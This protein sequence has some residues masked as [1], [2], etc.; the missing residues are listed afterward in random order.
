MSYTLL[1]KSVRFFYDFH[2]IDIPIACFSLTRWTSPKWPRPITFLSS[3]SPTF[4]RN[5]LSLVTTGWSINV[6]NQIRKQK[7]KSYEISYI[8]LSTK[9]TVWIS[10]LV[11]SVLHSSYST[12]SASMSPSFVS[13]RWSLSPSNRFRRPSKMCWR[14]EFLTQIGSIEGVV[15]FTTRNN[16]CKIKHIYLLF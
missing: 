13:W 3:K 10:F 2:C 14:R 7:T 1:S 12:N 5:F 9:F 15:I 11:M 6:N 4:T 16:S 8:H